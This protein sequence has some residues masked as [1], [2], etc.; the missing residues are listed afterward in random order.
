M[1]QIARLRELL[2]RAADQCLIAGFDG[3]IH[4]RIMVGD[5][6]IQDVLKTVIA[7]ER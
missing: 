5:G 1:R 6:T 7:K 4:L 2:D 3:E